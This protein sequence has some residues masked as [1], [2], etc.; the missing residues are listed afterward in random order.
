MAIT[1]TYF[2][3]G[4]SRGLGLE[5]VR[6]LLQDSNVHVIAAARNPSSSTGLQE[7]KKSH[8]SQLK[9]VALEV[10]DP[11]AVTRV[12]AELEK[13]Y[14]NGIDYLINNAGVGSSK[15]SSETTKEE[16]LSVYE[17][18]VV[19]P[20]LVTEAFAPLVRK[21]E[22]KVVVHVSSVM[23]SIESNTWGLFPAYRAS[24]AALNM[25]AAT[26]AIEF[27]TD[28]IANVVL[29]PGWVDTELGRTVGKPPLNAEQ[30]AAAQIKVIKSLTF[31]DNG[32]YRSFDGTTLPW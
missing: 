8:P 18:N 27:Q 14:P 20:F 1:T 3:T 32:K 31:A 30:S 13:E 25:L 11:A 19:G 10:T 23:G 24:K 7:L 4:T 22:R 2:I 15:L 26:L 12:A 9:L 6:Q 17:T 21:G 5:L 29:H 16:F 28:K